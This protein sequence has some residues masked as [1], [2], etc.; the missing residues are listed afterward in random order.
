MCYRTSQFFV[1]RHY[2]SHSPA[3]N[4]SIVDFSL[5]IRIA[6]YKGGCLIFLFSLILI[7]WALQR[8]LP[9]KP[10]EVFDD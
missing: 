8:C 7:A 5:Y 2:V 6:D 10:L 4:C 1:F 3:L 9:T